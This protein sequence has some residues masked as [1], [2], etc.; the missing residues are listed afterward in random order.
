VLFPPVAV[1]LFRGCHQVPARLGLSCLSIRCNQK[2]KSRTAKNNG[3]LCG[4]RRPLWI[5]FSASRD[6][7]RRCEDESGTSGKY[8]SCVAIAWQQT[9]SVLSC[10]HPFV[11]MCHL[12]STLVVGPD[13]I[14]PN[15]TMKITGWTTARP[16]SAYYTMPVH[17]LP[18]R[19][20]LDG[21]VERPSPILI[22]SRAAER[23][24]V[25]RFVGC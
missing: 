18:R 20:P 4:S 15:I 1:L 2:S 17:R 14:M 21:G 16:I 24:A 5:H 19:S 9:E 7:P 10:Q 25:I 11:A 13:G 3:S 8:A 6:W 23:H 12:G 22:H